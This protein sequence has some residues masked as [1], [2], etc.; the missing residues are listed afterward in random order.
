M[1]KI[2][3][4]IEDRLDQGSEQGGTPC[5]EAWTLCWVGRWLTYL[6]G[7]QAGSNTGPARPVRSGGGSAGLPWTPSH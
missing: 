7:E 3:G 2:L 6:A 1:T 5:P 4:Y